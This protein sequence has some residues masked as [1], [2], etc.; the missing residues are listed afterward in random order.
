MLGKNWKNEI[1]P[2]LRR[3][4]YRLV[5]EADV[6]D[7]RKMRMFF[8]DGRKGVD[9]VNI[10]HNSIPIALSTRHACANGTVYFK[11][12]SH[13]GDL[14]YAEL[15]QVPREE[16]IGGLDVSRPLCILFVVPI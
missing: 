2:C 5:V 10:K 12:Y 11:C 4:G 16:M 1:A 6:V 15:C 9:Q 8:F 14:E 13:A 7:G 3:E